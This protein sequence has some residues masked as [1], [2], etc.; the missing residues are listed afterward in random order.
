MWHFFSWGRSPASECTLLRSELKSMTSLHRKPLSD[1]SQASMILLHEAQAIP[2]VGCYQSYLGIRSKIR[3]ESLC[4]YLQD[5]ETTAL[6]W[7]LSRHCNA[8]VTLFKWWNAVSLRPN[9]SYPKRLCS[10]DRSV[11]CLQKISPS[12]KKHLL[13]LSLWM[14]SISKSIS[15]HWIVES[16]GC[17]NNIASRQVFGINQADT[18]IHN[19]KVM[20][21]LSPTAIAPWND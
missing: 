1:A 12:L 11:F 5:E 7:L 19:G 18:A 15:P 2:S 14:L 8:T 3:L 13:C 9:L 10:L 16:N 6:P 20:A 17:S 21:I 4:R